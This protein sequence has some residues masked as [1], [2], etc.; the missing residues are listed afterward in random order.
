M[1]LLK[2]LLRLIGRELDLDAGSG[3]EV[4]R[5]AIRRR[6][7]Q[8]LPRIVAGMASKGTT[9]EQA[10][11]RVVIRDALFRLW[12][13]VIPSGDLADLVRDAQN[14]RVL[15]LVEPQIE[16]ATPLEEAVRKTLDAALTVGL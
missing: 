7:E 6:M 12:R 5:G 13:Q 15:A 10:G 11:K 14:D 9:L 3:P 1:N 8:R 4:L 2:T 16:P